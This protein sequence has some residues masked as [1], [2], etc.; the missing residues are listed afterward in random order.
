[1]RKAYYLEQRAAKLAEKAAAKA[2]AEAAEAN[3]DQVRVLSFE[4]RLG[5]LLVSAS[6]LL[7]PRAKPQ[8]RI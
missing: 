6:P 3:G 7:W 5:C 2:S 8:R 4:A 1:M